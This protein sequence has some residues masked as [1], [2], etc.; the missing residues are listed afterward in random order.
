MKK[1]KDMDLPPVSITI[2]DEGMQ[3]KLEKIIKMHPEQNMPGEKAIPY[4]WDEA[5]FSTVFAELYM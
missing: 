5:G 2:D 3:A 1:E 4:T